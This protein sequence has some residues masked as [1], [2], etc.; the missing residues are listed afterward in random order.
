MP[1]RLS[2]VAI[3]LV[4]L[5]SV[6]ISAQTPAAPKPANDLDALMAQAL[7]RRDVDRRTLSDYVLDEIETFEVLGP[8]RAPLT[9]L[10]REYTWY[11]RD[12]VHVRSPLK[13][14][15]V[16][17]GE[18][19]RRKY[20]EE[21]F[22]HEQERRKHRAERE[23]ER[24]AQGKP[25]ALGPSALNEP[26]F[27]S[28]SYFLEFKFEPGNYYLAGR[29]TLDKHDVLRIDY[30]PTHLF[31]DDD[32]KDPKD[33]K[34]DAKDTK[35]TKES[36]KRDKHQDKEDQLEQDID[37]KMNKTAQVTLWVDPSEH[38]IVKYTFDN[39]WM[40]FLPGAWLVRVDD[41]RASMEMGQPFEGVWL[42]RNLAVHGGVTLA[43]GPL[44]ISYRREF[45]N[46]RLADV[47]TKI[48]VPKQ[49]I[50]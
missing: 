33:A 50:K 49:V 15:G 4:A 19:E 47:K 29:E 48:T 1:R 8:S 37:R 6:Q 14:D 26:R 43:S 13:F 25:P 17:I 9:R 22:Q 10:R 42:P 12:G 5:A 20:E 40:D 30:Y 34:K 31:D 2:R 36:K 27:V 41:I 39:V 7:Q 35:D 21:W 44:E 18:A 3:A 28:E 46:Y 45:S 38:R 23:A 24:E 32:D 11:V 16:P